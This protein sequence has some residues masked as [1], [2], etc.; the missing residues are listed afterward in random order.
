[1]PAPPRHPLL[2]L[3]AACLVCFVLPLAAG[4]AGPAGKTSSRGAPEASHADHTELTIYEVNIRQATPE[5]TFDA[6][7]EQHL[8][9]LD[10]MNVGILWLMPI[11]PISELNRKDDL[12]SYYAAR[13][14]KAVNPEFGNKASFRRFVNAAHDRG[15]LVILD[16]VPNHTGWDHVWT[17]TNPEWYTEGEDGGFTPPIEAWDDVIDLNY[18]NADMRAAMIDAM[19]YWV[20]EFDVDGF[21]CD[22]AAMVPRDF[23][24]TAIPAIRAERDVFMLA[25]AGEAWLHEA[26][27]DATYGWSFYG[28]LERVR[29]G[30]GAR[31]IIEWLVAEDAYLPDGAY[32]MLMTSN[33]DENSWNQTAPERWGDFYEAA[34]VLTF[35]LPGVPLIYTGQEVG[36]TE[37]LLFFSKDE[38]NWGDQPDLHPKAELYRSLAALKKRHPA[39]HHGADLAPAEILGTSAGND[40]L[41]FRRSVVDSNGEERSVTVLVNCLDTA[42]TTVLLETGESFRL[43]PYGWAIVEDRRRW[44][45]AR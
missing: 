29:D 5:G 43:R 44:P 41:A 42:R 32:R 40:V 15:M 23:W 13:D 30:S 45:G 1:M 19:V 35:T 21:R 20:R 27:F 14:Y 9:R 25:E 28:P 34:T 12:G 8:D 39:L 22:V 7:R 31:E 6:F 33:H 2:P 18:D 17:E 37:N 36:N 10:R 11:H 38:V 26:G 16:W 24:E 3:L 4:C